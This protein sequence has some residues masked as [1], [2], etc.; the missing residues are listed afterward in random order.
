MAVLQ[1]NEYDASYF[2]GASQVLKHNAGYSKYERWFRKHGVNSLGEFWKDK[3]KKIFDD[4]SL[5]NKKVLEIGCAK[6][7]VV[8]DLRDFGADAFGLDVSQYAIDN[9]EN[10]MSSFLTA[11]DARTSLSAYSA[12]EFDVVFS[13]R[14]LECIDDADLP[15]LIK[16]MNRISKFQFHV[17][18]E[19]VGY[20]EKT[21][22]AQFYNSHTLEDWVAMGFSKNSIFTSQENDTK[23]LTK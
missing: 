7:F 11:G 10:G 18:D 16:E 4:Y 23:V 9:A 21:G 2:D 17:V 19:F 6:G 20:P 8:K 13:L 22:A 15:S 1:P 3:A 5:L 12:N 14:F